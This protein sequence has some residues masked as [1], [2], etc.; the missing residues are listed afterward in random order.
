MRASGPLRIAV[1]LNPRIVG[2]TEHFLANLLTFLDRDRVLPIAVASE[3][4]PTTALFRERGIE[5]AIVPYASPGAQP[6]E[7][8]GFFRARQI[9]LVQSSYF[10]PVLGLAA[11]QAAI[12]H[13][14]RFGG[15]ISVVHEE[16]SAREKQVFLSLAT[17]LSQRIVCGSD[18]LRRQFQMIEHDDVQVIYNGLDTA[19]FSD[20]AENGDTRQPRVAMLAHFVPQKRHEDLI[21]AA[22]L[23]RQDIP[24]VRFDLFGACYPSDESERYAGSLRDLVAALDLDE[25][26]HFSYLGQQRLALLRAVTLF[27][28]PSVNEGASNAILEAMALGKPVIAADSGGNPELVDDGTT[29]FLVPPASPDVLAER[30]VFLLRSPETAVRFGAAARQRLEREFSIQRCATQYEQLYQD[31]AR[32]A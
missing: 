22:R 19:A 24:E 18:F 26:V 2:G 8:A 17:F 14:W 11:T 32:P 30:I 4:G 1:E 15:H 12:P 13:V 21:R 3:E 9:D 10:S 5:T 28:L 20:T 23:V 31:V 6:A 16:Q 7:I 27:V 29:G 25:T